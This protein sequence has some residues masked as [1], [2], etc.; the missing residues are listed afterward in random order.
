MTIK[1]GKRCSTSVAYLRHA[2]KEYKNLSIL[3]KCHT[4]KVLI[5][6]SKAVGVEYLKGN[7]L[8][9][10]RANKEIIICSG[11]INTPQLLM[12]SGIGDADELKKHGILINCHL[13]GVGNN[14]QDHLEIYMQYKCN[15]PITLYSFQWKFPIKMAS[16]GIQWFLNQTG[17][18]AT[19]H[20]EAGAFIRTSNKIPHP[21][22]QLHFVPSVVIDHGQRMPSC[23]AFQA[24]AGTMRAN[25]KGTVKLIS[26]NPLQHPEIDYNYLSTEKDRVD[27]RNCVKLTKEIFEQNVFKKYNKGFY[28]ETLVLETDDQI[29]NFIRKTCETA[30]HPCG[31]AKM[32]PENDKYAVVD[33]KCKV[34]G[35]DNLRIVDASIM[36]SI[37]S[38]N[39][40]APTIMMAEKASDIILKK[41]PLSK[42]EV[43]R[44]KPNQPKLQREY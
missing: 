32:G 3:S 15:Q 22:V 21:D 40:N 36:P 14:L 19:T 6:N 17:N 39:L 18:A 26:T 38:G 8:K 30:Y 35:V 5:E 31:T 37:V 20:F 25:S 13:P 11:A 23:H 34:F 43:P 1:N 42:L 28:D 24:N 12:L 44:W 16:T 4:T 41:P 33:S 10:I 2:L 9:T 27:M 7:E 29:D